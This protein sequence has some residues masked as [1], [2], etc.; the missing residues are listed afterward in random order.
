MKK[1]TIND[2]IK[3][4]QE[5]RKFA[6]STAY[7][8]SFAQLF[9]SQEVPVLLVGDS[10]GMVLQ[11]ENDTL[12]VT[13]DDIVYHTRCVRAG[14][15]NCLLMA[16]MPFMSYAT[17]EQACENAAKLMRAGA[18]MVK[19]EGGDWLVDTVKMLTERAVPVCAHLGLTP[20]SVN[21]FGGYKIQGRDQ[22][23]A[24][25]MVKD[26]LALQEAGAQI[27]LLE[28]VPAELAERITKVL[29]VPVIGIGAGNVTDGQI[30]VMHDM[31]G[32][33]ANYMP[34]FSKNFLAETGDMRKAVAKYIEDVANGVFPD[35]AHTIA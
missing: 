31:F 12:P 26:A 3:W 28:C 33:S 9:E 32:I 17:P 5:G 16:D 11:G 30:L 29:D 21:I 19:I 18:N 27:V 2:L 25:R 20:Q 10:L 34:K 15:P 23:K 35:D 24:D 1:M 6:T 13:V 7:D 8:A 4:K 14:S 22:E